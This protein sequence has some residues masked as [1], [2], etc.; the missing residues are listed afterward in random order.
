MLQVA[1]STILE[2]PQSTLYKTRE[3]Q[4]PC[5]LKTNLEIDLKR[6]NCGGLFASSPGVLTSASMRTRE[7]APSRACTPMVKAVN[8]SSTTIRSFRARDF[9]IDAKGVLNL[10]RTSLCFL[11]KDF[12]PSVSVYLSFVD[13]Q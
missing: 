4:S 8:F 5:Y 2:S 9:L 1:S 10:S 12:V 7:V 13:C 3:P 11:H 6:S